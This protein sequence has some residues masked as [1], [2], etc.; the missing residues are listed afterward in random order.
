MNTGFLRIRKYQKKVKSLAKV[1]SES[2]TIERARVE[3]SDVVSR[4]QFAG[5]R[6]VV[7]RRGKP[8]A[9]IVPLADLELLQRLEDELDADA[10]REALEEVREGRARPWS[11]VRESLGRRRT[12]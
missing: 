2:V 1:E 6:V 12:E 5:E 11:E 7:T 4:V 10:V 8:A 3:L 9:A